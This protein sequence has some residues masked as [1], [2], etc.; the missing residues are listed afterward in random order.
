MGGVVGQRRELRGDGLP[1]AVEVGEAFPDAVPVGLGGGGGQLS[2]GVQLSDQV[3]LGD[4]DLLDPQVQGGGLGVVLGLLLGHPG[5]EQ[6]REAFGAAG[7][8]QV[9][10]QP[11]PQGGCG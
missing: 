3:L 10:G 4:V 6:L 2:G 9:A 8:E 7:G 5:R 1:F 11:V